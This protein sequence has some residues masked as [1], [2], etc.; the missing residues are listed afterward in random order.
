MGLLNKC[1]THTHTHTAGCITSGG[2]VLS[3]FGVSMFGEQFQGGR[4]GWSPSPRHGGGK[5][6]QKW[7]YLACFQVD[8]DVV[9][10]RQFGR[11]GQD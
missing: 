1:V 9:C 6:R 10:T 2:S 7:H 8:D 3:P 4:S 5:K 11:G